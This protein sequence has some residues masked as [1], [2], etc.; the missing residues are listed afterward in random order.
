MTV[1]FTTW[2][3]PHGDPFARAEAS[4]DERSRSSDD[5]FVRA[6]AVLGYDAPR[7]G[8]ESANDLVIAFC[9]ADP[10]RRVAMPGIDP[11]RDGALRLLDAYHQRGA[12]GVVVSPADQGW[13]PTHTGV[14]EFFEA[15]AE[16]GLVVLSKNPGLLRRDSV[17]GFA[18][19]WHWDE[20]LRSMPTLKLVLGDHLVGGV[21]E[22]LA[23]CAKHRSAFA[24]TSGVLAR[25]IRL[26]DMLRSA[27]EFGVMDKVIFGSGSP[28]MSAADAA[29]RVYQVN[30]LGVRGDLDPIPRESLRAIVERDT[31]RALGVED[32]DA[33]PRGADVRAR[34]AVVRRGVNA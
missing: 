9:Q 14:R 27:H 5:T 4:T 12:I 29:E 13:C 23:L 25:P 22:S 16:R 30:G 11:L 18:R 31:F 2:F 21:D 24:E 6:R 15:C 17:L 32:F 8:V 1:D 33:M 28:A 34:R 10:L 20:V 3:W 26:H 19:V 7:L